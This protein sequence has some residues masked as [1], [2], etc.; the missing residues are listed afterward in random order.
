MKNAFKK[1]VFGSVLLY[2]ILLIVVVAL[3]HF[4]IPV[5]L[6]YPP[7]SINNEFETLIDMGY[8]YT[9]Q[10]ITISV[11]GILV[12]NVLLI[13]QIRK[14]NGWQ[15]IADGTLNDEEKKEKIK[16]VCFTAPGK[17]YLVHV[18]I[19]TVA[20]MIGLPAT[21]SWCFVNSKNFCLY[22]C[23]FYGSGPSN[24]YTF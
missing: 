12:S 7:N 21:R 3:F 13:A 20:I 18:L 24:L 6:N 8:K 2:N 16:Y 4:A 23:Y 22:A 14:I 11:L 10:F 15:K 9:Q 19:P 5:L 17:L 1:K